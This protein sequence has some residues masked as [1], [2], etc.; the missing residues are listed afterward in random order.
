MKKATQQSSPKRSD[1][2]GNS[3]RSQHQRIEQALRDNPHGLTT[4]E[5][6]EGYDV[7]RPGARICEM[8]WD[9]GLNIKSI[10]VSDTTAMGKPHRVVRYLLLPGTW[11]AP[12]KA[13]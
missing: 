2:N 10:R 11:E 4:I 12:K 8:R 7:L 13:A 6:V 9:L 3:I 5:L 1:L